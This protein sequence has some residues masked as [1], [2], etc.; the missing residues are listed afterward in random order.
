MAS[1][2]KS[3]PTRFPHPSSIHLHHYM[4]T[5]S[6]ARRTHRPSPVTCNVCS[7]SFAR[8]AKL[9]QHILNQKDP[10]H[11]QEFED[12]VGK[13]SCE[14]CK[15]RFKNSA[16]YR[17]HASAYTVNRFVAQLECC[18][19]NLE[20]VSD[21]AIREMLQCQALAQPLLEEVVVNDITMTERWAIHLQNHFDFNQFSTPDYSARDFIMGI[22]CLVLRD[23]S[24]IEEGYVAIITLQREHFLDLTGHTGLLNLTGHGGLGHLK[25]ELLR[26]CHVRRVA[27]ATL[28]LLQNI[29]KSWASKDITKS[30]ETL[31][32]EDSMESS[33]GPSE[34]KETEPPSSCEVGNLLP[35]H[36]IDQTTR[37]TFTPSNF[38]AIPYDPGDFN[39]YDSY[40]LS[41]NFNVQAYNGPPFNPETWSQCGTIAW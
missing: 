16:G 32:T 7:Q 1:S 22:W 23:V 37:A 3:F 27:E 18:A 17:R 41:P 30:K 11:Q 26:S 24:Q 33:N 6:G 4:M 36:T 10:Q 39:T 35:K 25:A 28:P 38:N 2:T 9:K 15:Q 29:R 20:Q 21:L 14:S 19:R 12:N 31:R 13:S 8:L 5:E 34:K 40:Q